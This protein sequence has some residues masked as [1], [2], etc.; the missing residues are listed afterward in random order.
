MAR[1]GIKVLDDVN[2]LILDDSE[3]M[4]RLLGTMVGGWLK[5]RLYMCRSTE[6]A[7]ETLETDELDLALVDR[8]LWGECGLEFVRTLRARTGPTQHMPIVAMTVDPARD[9]ILECLL[10]GANS[11]LAKPLSIRT[12]ALHLH[13]LLACNSAFVPLGPIV[14]PVSGQVA[15]H[16]GADPDGWRV[17]EAI[18]SPLY[19]RL[20]GEPA[21][22]MELPA[23][24][25]P[26]EMS[27]D[28]GNHFA[29]I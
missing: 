14:L 9:V 16:L 18:A 17:V 5:G 13:N 8:E 27:A 10:S 6:E 12:L 23:A 11:V 20:P 28:E 4:Q 19:R 29:L 25:K 26:P 1:R 21:R 3:A 7:L 2:I 24:P 22:G 15:G